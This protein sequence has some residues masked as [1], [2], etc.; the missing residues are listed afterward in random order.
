MDK[1]CMCSCGLVSVV[2]SGVLVLLLVNSG[3]SEYVNSTTNIFGKNFNEG[4]QFST[5]IPKKPFT[6]KNNFLSFETKDEN[7]EVYRTEM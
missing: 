4:F 2:V 5:R 6:K 7:I 1:K 3:V